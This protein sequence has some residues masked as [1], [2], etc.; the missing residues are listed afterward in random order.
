MRPGDIVTHLFHGRA[1][2]IVDDD[3]RVLASARRARERGVTMDIGHGGGSFTFR[4]ARAALADGF[5]PDTLST[6]L[7][8]IS[9]AGACKDL[10]TTMGKFVALGMPLDRVVAATT[11]NA[12]RAIGHPDVAGTLI[13][14][15][16]AD[17][18]I[19][20]EVA[21]PVT[22]EDVVGERIAGRLG[23]PAVAHDPRGDMTQPPMTSET[24]GN[25]DPLRGGYS[26]ARGAAREPRNMHAR[27]VHLEEGH[28]T[29]CLGRAGDV[30]RH[31]GRLRDAR[32]DHGTISGRDGRTINGRAADRGT[33]NRGS[34]RGGNRCPE[35]GARPRPR[36][37][38]RQQ[39]RARRA[40]RV[41][42]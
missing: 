10:P 35:R 3:G 13:P 14:G 31:P 39:P 30:C 37:P 5:E 16:A 41:A 24:A 19:F 34:E 2:T 42:R 6:D 8:T 20:D 4:T 32:S 17:I 18:A 12:A 21:G 25:P 28:A 15:T 27:P 1:Q 36:R 38:H 26:L 9:I 33:G 40:E 11:I 23:A 22:Y 29:S 7:H